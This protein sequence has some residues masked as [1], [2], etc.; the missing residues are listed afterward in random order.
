VTGGL[1]FFGGPGSNYLTHSIAAMALRLREGGGVGFIH[2][3]GEMMTKHHGLVLGAEPHG[4]GYAA[5]PAGVVA[6]APAPVVIDDGYEG[7]GTIE[8][9]SVAYGRDGTPDYGIVIG[10]GSRGERFGA[11]VD[12]ADTAT[13][14]ALASEDAEAIGTSGQV[15]TTTRGSRF[16]ID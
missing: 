9:C 5:D 1:S 14:A 2:G 6:V 4:R 12:A 13:I 11:Q 3:V 10:R 16:T 7:R 8:T 15:T